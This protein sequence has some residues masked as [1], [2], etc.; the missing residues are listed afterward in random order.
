M[1]LHGELPEVIYSWVFSR[2][3]KEMNPTVKWLKPAMNNFSLSS[4]DVFYLAGI[5]AGGLS[6]GLRAS[7]WQIQDNISEVKGEIF[8]QYVS[9]VREVSTN[10]TQAIIC[11][12]CSTVKT[13]C[14]FGKNEDL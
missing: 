9:G 11:M 8:S 5:L 7:V 12:K 10:C 14:V 3:G 1:T 13:K 4:P 2:E 6:D